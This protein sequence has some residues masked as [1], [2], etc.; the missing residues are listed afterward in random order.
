[1]R[2]QIGDWYL[3]ESADDLLEFRE[4][5]QKAAQHTD[6]SIVDISEDPLEYPVFAYPHIDQEEEKALTMWL[7]YLDSQSVDLMSTA[8]TDSTNDSD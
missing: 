1:M 3:L 6:F 4:R 2:L 7:V 5:Q 8:F